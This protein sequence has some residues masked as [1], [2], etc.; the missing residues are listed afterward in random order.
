MLTRLM[1]LLAVGLLC[2]GATGCVKHV[3]AKCQPQAPDLSN[4]S[5]IQ[6]QGLGFLNVSGMPVGEVFELDPVGT[7]G[8]NFYA[9]HV[10]AL[11]YSAAPASTDYTEAPPQ[12]TTVSVAVSWQL[13]G[14]VTEA[15]AK[16]VTIH[17]ALDDT[18]SFAVKN[19]IRAY[20]N[21]TLQSLDNPANANV[22]S[23]ITAHPKLTYLI[24][25]P[26][27]L[28]N[29][30][31]L[32]VTNAL[33]ADANVKLG[34]AVSADVKYDCKSDALIQA[35]P[36]APKA[37]LIVYPEFI[38]ADANGAI[39]HVGGTSGPHLFAATPPREITSLALADAKKRRQGPQSIKVVLCKKTG[40]DLNAYPGCKNQ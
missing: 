31:D 1:G 10:G 27:E 34:W 12:D 6:T 5:A 26:V 21:N 7:D 3:T 4:F 29:S 36:N 8:K 25:N 9:N 28:G 15:S 39:N 17:A 24:V 35:I 20:I 16:S 22:K 38:R 33:K 13:S 23:I 14:D 11:Q 19:G 37:T 40:N 30:A 2:L 18:L 32:A